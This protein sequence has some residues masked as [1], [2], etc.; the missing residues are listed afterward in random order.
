MFSD[1]CINFSALYRGNRW[2]WSDQVGINVFNNWLVRGI[3]AESCSCK[4]Q[5]VRVIIVQLLVSRAVC[6][7]KYR[8]P[9]HKH[10]SL[11]NV[12]RI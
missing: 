11:Q 4:C 9:S 6:A 7:D 2:Y 1:I 10:P 5:F 3:L 8:H 12:F